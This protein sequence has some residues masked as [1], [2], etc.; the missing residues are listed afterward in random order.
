MTQPPWSRAD[1]FTD[2]EPASTLPMIPPGE[3]SGYADTTPVP[4]ASVRP[5][6]PS[7]LAPLRITLFDLMAEIRKNNRVCP[8][9]TRWLDFY[10][11]LEEAAAGAP[12]PSPPLVGAAWAATPSLAKRMCFR[13]QLEWAAAHDCMNPVYQYLKS[14]GE[15]DWHYMG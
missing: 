15:A 11:L 13:E 4:L 5:V 6:A 1:S 3:E 9:P 8:V 10:R 12:L 14:L 2:S 7:P